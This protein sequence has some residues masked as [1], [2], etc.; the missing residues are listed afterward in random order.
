MTDFAE[1]PVASVWPGLFAAMRRPPAPHVRPWIGWILPAI[2]L[3]AWQASASLGW[4]SDT[5][6]PSPYA[7]ATAAWRLTLSG[8]LPQNLGVS[9]LRALAGLAVGGGVGLAL[10]L[11][12]G[13]SRFSFS[14]TDT[15]VQMIRIDEP[16]GALDA[17]TRLEMQRLIEQVW[18]SK[19]FTAILV[20]HDVTEAVTLGE[21][22][23][24]IDR[25]AIAAD[26]PVD[27]A[28]P[29]RRGLP[30]FARVEAEVLERL[31]Q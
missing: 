2:V 8:G 1:K 26:I 17:L 25:G 23:V 19:G 31:L 30:E 22:I 27:L 16:L 14:A 11:L 13:L 5:V 21:R 6:M 29:R 3:V 20:T 12:N 18:L 28:R 15:S 4:I 10:G 7:V 9:A 24:V